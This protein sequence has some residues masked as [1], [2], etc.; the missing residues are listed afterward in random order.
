MRDK[1][2]MTVAI[3]VGLILGAIAMPVVSAGSAYA[4]EIVRVRGTIESIDGSTYVVKTRD[5][6]EQKVALAPNAQVAGVVKA[7]LADVKPGSFVGVTALAQP[8][9]TQHA[10]EVHIF[11]ESMRVPV[12]DTLPGISNR[13]AR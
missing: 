11:P 12:K 4:D 2:K 1:Y 7:S 10:L 8:D 9:G 6:A 13:T 3:F 5:G